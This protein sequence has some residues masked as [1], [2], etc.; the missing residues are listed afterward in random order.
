M[1][2]QPPL[3]AASEEERASARFELRYED[4]SQDGQVK[5]TALP[6]AVG[7]AC[8]AGLWVRH[9][10]IA[11]YR[12][13][14]VPIL[15]HMVIE[16]EPQPTL[17]GASIEAQGQLQ[18]AHER[19][20]VKTDANAEGKTNR[21]LP[22]EV[23][24]LFLNMIAEVFAPLGRSFGPQPDDFGKRVR[25]GRVFAEHVFTK[26]FGP[27]EERKVLKFS[28]PGQPEIP[29]SRY[30]RARATDLLRVPEGAQLLDAELRADPSPWVF[31][32]VHSDNNQHV[33]SLVYPRL[34]EETALR[35]FGEHGQSLRMLGSVL[36]IVYRKPC[37]VGDRVTCSLQTYVDADGTKVAVGVVAPP[38]A[39]PDKAHCTMRLRMRDVAAR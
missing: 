39:S 6:V 1:E 36:E 4:L 21:P 3:P 37:F 15:S 33:N 26:P 5:L 30:D 35:R 29:P 22:G 38:G 23:S 12:D 2:A 25:I 9:P 34:F 19:H 20:E 16:S 10:L 31:G 32:L 28:V 24:G 11:T 18:L 27:R 8:F 14:I 13:G 17:L 7:R